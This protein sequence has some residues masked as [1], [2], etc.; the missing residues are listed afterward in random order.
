[1][2]PTTPAV[3]ALLVDLDGV[4]RLW[5]RRSADRAA[6]ACG[7]PPGSVRELAYGPA[8]DLAHLGRLTHE[9][10]VDGVREDLVQRYGPAAAV[11]ADLWAADRGEI[12]PAMVNLLLRARATGLTVATLTNNTSVLPEDLRLHR[13]DALFDHVVNSADIAVAK[14]SAAAYVRALQHLGMTA[15]S[16]AFTDDNPKNATAAA[17]LGLH[18]HHYLDAVGFEQFLNSL[19]ICLPPLTVATGPVT[20]TAPP[21]G[22]AEADAPGRSTVRYL[23]RPGGARRPADDLTAAVDP[24][25]AVSWDSQG[26]MTT[27]RLGTPQ[28]SAVHQAGHDSSWKP[29][30]AASAAGAFEHLPPW[31][32]ST[33]AQAAPYAEQLLNRAAWALHRTADRHTED[34]L[35]AVCALDEVRCA[36]TALATLLERRQPVP[37]PD[38]AAA[39]YLPDHIVEALTSSHAAVPLT[40]QGLREAVE[41]LLPLLRHLRRQTVLVL[42]IDP[43]WPWDRTAAALAPLLDRVPD[44][45]PQQVPGRLYT[46]ALAA[47]YD[48]HRPVAA[49]MATALSG[50]A[51]VE[52]DGSDVVELGAGTGRITRHLAAPAAASYTAVEPAPAM[53]RYLHELELPGLHVIE[54]DALALPLGTASTD[55]VIEHEAFLFT[56]D[57]LLACSEAI[58]VLRP[59]GRL[60]RLLLHRDHPDPLACI[61]DAYREAAFANLPLPLVRGTG[62]DPLITTHLAARQLATRTEV[63]TTWSEPRTAEHVLAALDDRA[64][65]W[66]HQADAARHHTGMH[67]AR[68]K[69]RTLSAGTASVSYTLRALTTTNTTEQEAP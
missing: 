7:L 34:P 17:G 62:T 55:L 5:P 48:R 33:R 4:V 41:P 44:L 42:Q 24:H 39:R 15:G 3:R 9:Q 54:A 16:V 23:A 31:T 66:T 35:A 43:V 26:S 21:P 49:P 59:G 51:R 64:W 20:G 22:H 50:L 1:M 68:Q 8:F 25:I 28:M 30:A 36:L 32:A 46:P 57:P 40:G 19:G 60:I 6:S 47:V 45:A 69:A 10:W 29:G 38:A 52:L 13:L 53:A 2:T 67:A 58:R 61:E 37:W 14:P 65:P 18:A 27:W 11:A 12:D 63:L 56:D